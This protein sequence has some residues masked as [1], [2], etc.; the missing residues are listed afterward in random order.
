[1]AKRAFIIHGFGGNPYCNWF[2]WLKAELTKRGYEVLVPAMPN[3][4]KPKAT[5]WVNCISKTV[6]APT[7]SD[8]L[9]GHS[10]GVIAILRYLQQLGQGQEVGGA[11]LVAGFSY[12]LGINELYNFVDSPVDWAS[13]KKHCSKFVALHSDNDPYITLASGDIFKE[14]LGAKLVVKHNVGHFLDAQLPE[15]LNAVLELSD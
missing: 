1:M 7:A 4:S 14:K 15:V 12:D 9:I 5:E 10:L 13:I 11:V 3:P 8:Y 2:P 6:G